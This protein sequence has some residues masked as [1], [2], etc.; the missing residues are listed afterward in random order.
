[1]NDDRPRRRRRSIDQPASGGRLPLFPLFI[2]V[3]LAGLALGAFISQRFNSPSR[4]TPFAIHAPT[5]T[6][7]IAATPIHRTAIN[8]PAVRT[9]RTPL[10]T[11]SASAMRSP[12]AFPS[13][14]ARATPR[15]V[16][17]VALTTPKPG[18][19]KPIAVPV[20]KSA[21]TAGSTAIA[22]PIARPAPPAPASGADAA[23]GVARDYLSAVMRGDNRTANSALGKS[24][25]SVPDFQEQS[26]LTPSSHI[27]SV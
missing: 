13:A 17:R 11:P 22:R 6:P 14:T 4:S 2:V 1:M 24:P 10:A 25:N 20:V 12:S 19:V 21:P 15:P 5:A 23:A 26:F 16:H 18:A 9:S 27:N 7:L 8:S 3:V